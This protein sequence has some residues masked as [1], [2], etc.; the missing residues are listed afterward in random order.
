MA[1][2]SRILLAVDG[3]EQ[4]LAAV[5]YVGKI[6]NKNTEIVLFHVGSDIPE[7]FKDMNTDRSTILGQIPFEI[8]KAHQEETIKG[9]MGKGRSI[10]IGFGFDPKAVEVKVQNLNY[11]IARD[12]HRESCSNYDALVVG[13]TGVSG[14]DDILM[15]SVASK[16]VE[17]SSHIPIIVVGEHADSSKIL[18]A[19]DGSEGSMKA[20][21]FAADSLTT[22]ACEIMLC[23]VIRPLM[24][25]QL[26]PKDLFMSKHE[27]EWIASNQRK[28]IPLIIEA[29]NR[30]IKAG[31]SEDQLSR[32]ILTYQQSRAAAIVKAAA[33]NGCGTI[34]LG[35][36]GFTSVDKFSMGR[37]SRKILYFAYRPALWIVN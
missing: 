35:R 12:I 36:R 16:L 2:K 9:F 13:R 14:L 11:G 27:A 15:G 18:I 22:G 31:H 24:L 23:H 17:V 1:K 19:I 4:S 34:V 30:L 28:A 20:V 6:L 10:L 25:A 21:N 5:R 7:V 33:D 29:K 26:K 8:W 37:V 3:S 32:E